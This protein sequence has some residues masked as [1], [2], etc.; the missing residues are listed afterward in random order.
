MDGTSTG[1]TRSRTARFLAPA[2]LVLALV[3]AGC[4]DD[5]YDNAPRPPIPIQLG[6]VITDGDVR[7]SPN[8]PSSETTDNGIATTDEQEA[9]DTPAMTEIGAGPTMVVVSNQSGR[10]QDMT[11]ESADD[12]GNQRA[13]IR[14]DVP[15]ID[16]QDTE[17]I[18]VNF[19][20]G[21]YTLRT[22]DS[23]IAPGTLMVGEQRPTGSNTLLL[24]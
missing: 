6:V 10:S 18:Q 5:N 19:P 20:E 24:P 12:P 1:G 17:Y 21:Q 2:L 16:P 3:A 11:I 15:Q 4:Q 23:G 9:D 13:G 22:Q 14:Q 7:V 8:S